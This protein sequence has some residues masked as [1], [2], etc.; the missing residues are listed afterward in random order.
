MIP[1][2]YSASIARAIVVDISISAIL[3]NAVGTDFLMVHV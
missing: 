3:G 1:K 2:G